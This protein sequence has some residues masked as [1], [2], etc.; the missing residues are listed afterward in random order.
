M[1]IKWGERAKAALARSVNEDIETLR[2]M[3]AWVEESRARQA[4]DAK[5]V[6]AAKIGKPKA[7]KGAKMPKWNDVQRYNMHEALTALTSPKSS[8]KTKKGAIVTLRA[9]GVISMHDDTE[10]AIKAVAKELGYI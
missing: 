5:A 3:R 8:K 2:E 10:Y 4:R 7:K 6:V 9:M 1:S